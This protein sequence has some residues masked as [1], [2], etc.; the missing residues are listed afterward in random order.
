LLHG[1]AFGAQELSVLAA[2]AA[3]KHGD[4]SDTASHEEQ[5]EAPSDSDSSAFLSGDVGGV[6]G[7][8]SADGST[9]VIVVVVS[10]VDDHRSLLYRLRRGW[11]VVGRGWLGIA[12][13]WG[14]ST[15]CRSTVCGDAI[16]LGRSVHIVIDL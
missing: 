7:A 5:A 12:V 3:A 9:G 1:L 10:Q 14:G 4:G 6:M 13:S 2:L 15:V 16:G 8:D 11:R